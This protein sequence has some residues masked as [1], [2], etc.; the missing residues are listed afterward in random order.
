SL[1]DALRPD[2]VGLLHDQRPKEHKEG[3]YERRRDLLHHTRG[4]PARTQPRRPPRELR[5]VHPCDVEHLLRS[6]DAAAAIWQDGVAAHPLRLPRAL[7]GAGVLLLLLRHQHSVGGPRRRLVRALLL[8]VGDWRDGH[9]GFVGLVEL[10]F[11]CSCQGESVKPRQ[12]Q[13]ATIN[14]AGQ[15]ASFRAYCAP[16]PLPRA[17]SG[18]PPPPPPPPEAWRGCTRRRR[19]P[20]LTAPRKPQI[21][22]RRSQRRCAQ[23]EV[24]RPRRR[25]ERAAAA[26]EAEARGQAEAEAAAATTLSS[27]I[28][29]CQTPTYPRKRAQAR[30]GVGGRH[31]RLDSLA[32]LRAS[33]CLEPDLC[34][35]FGLVPFHF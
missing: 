3:L 28:G 21:S 15:A 32:S 14:T 22:R 10:I 23:R 7:G 11:G 31:R 33:P 9:N 5:R 26:A 13:A 1:H 27:G 2:Q 12:R 34:A 4:A 24:R 8:L 35:P 6:A 25:R 18:A 19:A 16:S 30:R 20:P 17:A 29:T